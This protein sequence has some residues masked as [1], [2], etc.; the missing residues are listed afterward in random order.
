[1][2]GPFNSNLCLFRPARTWRRDDFVDGSGH[3]GTWLFWNSRSIQIQFRYSCGPGHARLRHFLLDGG[4]CRVAGFFLTF[5]MQHAPIMTSR[6]KPC[7][8][9]SHSCENVADTTTNYSSAPVVRRRWRLLR[10]LQMGD[11]RRDGHRR[12]GPAHCPAVVSVWRIAFVKQ[13]TKSVCHQLRL[14]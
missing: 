5:L 3:G 4:M 12:N 2:V 7:C 11:G 8:P 9:I 10:V 13:T 1:V 6:W 14:F